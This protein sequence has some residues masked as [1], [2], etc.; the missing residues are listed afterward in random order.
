MVFELVESA[1]ERWRALTGASLGA[2]VR[3]G[4]RFEKGVLIDEH[5]GIAA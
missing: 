5:T 4:A 3:S 1:Q 2:L